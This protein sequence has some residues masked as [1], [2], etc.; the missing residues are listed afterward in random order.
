MWMVVT[1]EDNVL[2]CLS[3]IE[4]EITWFSIVLHS[5]RLLLTDFH[6]VIL[7]FAQIS[8]IRFED[9]T[10]GFRMGN[11]PNG[12]FPK[13]RNDRTILASIYQLSR[14]IKAHK[15]VWITNSTRA[16]LLEIIKIK[17]LPVLSVISVP[18][19][20][21]VHHFVFTGLSNVSVKLVSLAG[22]QTQV[23]SIISY[24]Y[25]WFC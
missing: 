11:F 10:G 20:E 6:A 17:C 22:N 14:H 12:D 21:R 3:D 15:V 24:S 1:E 19:M 5:K 7:K 8:T 9:V 4:R 25:T 18:V 2:K 23:P 13:Q 16:S